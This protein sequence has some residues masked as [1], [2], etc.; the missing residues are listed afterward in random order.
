MDKAAIIPTESGLQAEKQFGGYTIVE[1]L[2]KG[3]MGDVFKALQTG[4]DRMVALKILPSLLARST[5]FSERFFTEAYAIS[6]LQHQNIVTIY[7]Y[8][9]ENG[10]KFIAMQ[11]VQGTTLSKL[12]QNEKKLDYQRIIGITKQICRGLKYAHHNEIVHR[13]IKSG[14]IMVEPGD[15]VFISDFGIAK[16]IDAPSITTTGMAMGTPEYMAPEQ[17][18]GGLVDGQS[19]IYGLG[20]II[21]EMVTGRPPFLADTPLAVAYKQVHETPPLLSKKATNVPPRLELIVAKCLKKAKA[22]RYLKADDLLRDLDSA[23]LDLSPEMVI[24][25]NQAPSDL[26]ITDRRNKDRRYTGEPMAMSRGY[27][28]GILVLF[29]IILGTLAFLLLRPASG[30]ATGVRW[31]VPSSSSG[32]HSPAGPTGP[33]PVEN[34]F[35]GKRSTAWVA[36]TGAT[37]GEAEIHFSF[38]GSTLLTGIAIEAGFQN[39]DGSAPAFSFPKSVILESEGRKPLRL[40]LSESDGVQYLGLGGILMQKGKLRFSAG[41]SGAAAAPAKPIAVREVRFLGLPYE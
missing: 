10:Q 11:Y 8:G 7:D 34:L 28:W 14:N 16:V 38:P 19:D 29:A 18:E 35:D 6:R 36:P 15:K 9:E 32:P 31:I 3:G 26:R 24:Q 2:G 40:N 37:P 4:L 25:K 30:I 17:C 21:Y 22:D 5:E 39:A 33:A 23:H 41:A 20:I 27:L 1:H 13:D 12:I